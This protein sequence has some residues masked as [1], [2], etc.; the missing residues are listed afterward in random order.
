M[1]FNDGDMREMWKA[2]RKTRKMRLLQEKDL[3]IMHKEFQEKKGRQASYMQRL[4]GKDAQKE[5]VQIIQLQTQ[6]AYFI[7]QYFFVLTNAFRA[8]I[9]SR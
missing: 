9:R 3:R 6:V 7:F 1:I 2:E 8:S 5:K 4:L